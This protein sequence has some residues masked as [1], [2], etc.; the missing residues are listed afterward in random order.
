MTDLNVALILRLVDQVTGPLRRLDG[1]IRG[2]LDRSG[3]A[4]RRAGGAMS[5]AVTAPLGVAG[6]SILRS[7]GDFEAA[8]NK[9]AAIS[10]ATGDE[11][12]LLADTAKRMGAATKFSA[13]EAAD[14]LGFLAMAGFD[15]TEAAEALPGVLSLAAAAGMDLASTADIASNV[16]SGYGMEV[17]QLAR[18]NDVLVKTFTSA[19][20]DL[21]RLGDAMSYA[22][23]VARTAGL[24]FEEVAAAIG[25]LGDAGIQGSRAGTA[26]LGSIAKMMSPSKE[27][28][29]VM[30]DLGL[31]F[32]DATGQLRPLSEIIEQLGPHSQD[33]ALMLELFGTE[34]GPG[35]AALVGRGADA[36]RDLTAELEASGGAADRVA[37]QQ[38]TG[39]NAALTSLSSAFE[40][41]QIA[42]AES[43]LLEFVTSL[44]EKIT[45]IVREAG[46]ADPRIL[47]LGTVIAGVAAAAGP[48]LIALGLMASGA[49]RLVSAFGGLVRAAIWLGGGAMSVLA[50]GLRLVFNLVRRHPFALL[51]AAA[52]AIIRN[53]EPIRDFFVGLWERVSG[54]WT[55]AAANGEGF[56]GRLTAAAEALLGSA[57][58]GVGQLFDHVMRGIGDAFDAAR[59]T[60]DA[61]MAALGGPSTQ[62]MIDAWSGVQAF[63]TDL[64]AGVRSAFETAWE[65]IRPIVERIGA[66]VETIR[67][68]LP[69]MGSLNP[70]N[71]FGGDEAPAGRAI[72]GARAAGGPVR[73]GG[74]YLV[75]EGGPELF[76]AGASGSILSAART[77]AALAGAASMAAPLAAEPLRLDARPALSAPA[78][79]EGGAGG[80]LSVGAIHIHAA[81]GMDA[82]AVAR[83]VRE[84]LA[85]M[86]RGAGALHD[87]ANTGGRGW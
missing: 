59:P 25:L 28:A 2:A 74:L 8:M 34:A 40:G 85:R 26:L 76:R 46:A 13:T 33:A 19:N 79:A 29:K 14:A 47:K 27:Q 10:G 68:A 6:A 44:V 18:V 31:S 80:G 63:F 53:W 4:M 1:S 51:I 24:D 75:G 87:R 35:M 72:D 77:A 69:S 84:E 9:V 37:S 7:A 5:L 73:R 39:L 60:I 81:P 16:L 66:S 67:S 38:A 50:G 83:A 86:A 52:V 48:A 58:E 62:R 17:D 12:T 55:E 36:L 57:W 64:W 45:D 21:R 15:A 43:G 30:T 42:I 11:L 54:A 23:P 22:A 41:L 3:A 32:T 49:G 61:V 71:W 78:P 20:T 70:L 56:V 65:F 82:A